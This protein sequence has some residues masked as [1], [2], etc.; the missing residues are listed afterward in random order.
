MEG[1]INPCS[2]CNRRVPSNA[3]KLKCDC[4]LCYIHSN[5]TS[6]SKSVIDKLLAT[7]KRSWSC[8]HCNA[9]NFPFNNIIEEPAFIDALPIERSHDTYNILQSNKLFNLFDMNEEKGHVKVLENDLDPD[10]NYFNELMVA[11]NINSNYYL[12]NDFYKYTMNSN[13]DNDCLSL[14]HNNIRS[15][16]SNLDNFLAYLETLSYDFDVIG[17]SET[18][19]N[20]NN[21]DLFDIAGYNHIGAP[22][23]Y[24]K[25]GGVSIYLK[26]SIPYTRRDDLKFKSDYFECIFIELCLHRKFLVGVVYRPPGSSIVS[27]NDE[28]CHLLDTIKLE[29]VPCYLLGD[30]NINIINSSSHNAIGTFVENMYSRGLN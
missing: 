30:Y 6:M 1:P 8:I 7:E 29:D 10:T 12:E 20:E 9:N 11:S 13:G 2:V 21:M 5:C 24:A 19:L 3:R 4:C 14:I 27:F 23:T 28:F 17:L 25:G 22:R 26:D 15:T 16:N 18:W